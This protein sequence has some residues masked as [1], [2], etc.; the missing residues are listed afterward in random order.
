[1]C[2]GAGGL[3]AEGSLAAI[4]EAVN[5]FSHKHPPLR[6]DLLLAV[7]VAGQMASHEVVNYMVRENH[8]AP[9]AV[10]TS[11]VTNHEISLGNKGRVDVHVEIRGVSCHS[12][13]PHQ[14]RNAIEG[15]RLFL[16]RLQE[17]RFDRADPHLG[18]ITLT[19]T[20]ME[21]WPKAMHTVP[22]LCRIILDRRLLPGE[23]PEQAVQQIRE[24]IGQ[25]G[26]FPI[27]IRAGKFNYPGKVREDCELVVKA[28]E[29]VRSVVGRAGTFYQSSTLD[30]GYFL[31][32]G[33]DTIHLGPGD[34]RFAHSDF[35]LIPV[36]QVAEAAEYYHRLLWLMAAEG[37][38]G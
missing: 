8:L 26:E 1:M 35:E 10:I 2:G 21:T 17:L 14:G 15:A 22:S 38:A 20:H 7:T 18:E 32:K 30:A 25:L 11:G 28:K 34:S 31:R 36:R 16:N 5:T 27:E 13:S 29:A 23:E 37:A 33:I 12:S 24:H 3:R 6:R 19:P 4:L 9:D